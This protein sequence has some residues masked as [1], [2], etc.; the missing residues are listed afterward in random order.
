MV[1]L[2][3]D[4][5]QLEVWMVGQWLACRLV[6]LLNLVC[7]SV[8]PSGWLAIPPTTDS[9]ATHT[10]IYSTADQPTKDG[11]FI[12]ISDHC[13]NFRYQGP[14]F[15]RFH[16]VGCGG[17][18]WPMPASHWSSLRSVSSSLYG[19]YIPSR[20]DGHSRID[21]GTLSKS[22][23][24]ALPCHVSVPIFSCYIQ[25][26][27]LPDQL[28]VMGWDRYLVTPPAWVQPAPSGSKSWI[29]ARFGEHITNFSILVWFKTLLNG[30]KRFKCFTSYEPSF[31]GEEG[32]VPPWF[33]PMT[34]PS[35]LG[36]IWGDTLG[37]LKQ[38][39]RYYYMFSI[40]WNFS[41]KDV[42]TVLPD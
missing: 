13:L 15:P 24:F 7:R 27:M 8:E 17:T 40:L 22:V 26:T 38:C 12:I 32:R 20:L 35:I 36:T 28:L 34:W 4:R 21:L 33:A 30:L 41:H 10:F 9:P 14:M 25:L 42:L 39:Q 18:A 11:S 3:A 2:L 23:W 16:P 29:N 5:S 1:G 19:G 31:G 37:Q 6:C